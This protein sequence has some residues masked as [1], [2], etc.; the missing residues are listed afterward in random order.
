MAARLVN[1]ADSRNDDV[2]GKQRFV[3][4]RAPRAYV[5]VFVSTDWRSSE[6]GWGVGE[7]GG[8]VGEGILIFFRIVHVAVAS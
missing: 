5:P 3:L 6:R 2:E 4:W 1:M 8:G 7:G